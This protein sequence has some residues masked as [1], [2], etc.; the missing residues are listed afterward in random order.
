MTYKEIYTMISSAGYPCA[1]YQY[2]EGE[3]PALP[4]ILYYYPERNDFGA[5]NTNYA[6]ATDLNIEFYSAEKDFDAEAA[7]EQIL[8]SND[9]WYSKEEQYIDSE[10][11]Y[12]VL[13]T[14]T[15]PIREDDPEPAPEP[16]DPTEPADPEEPTEPTDPASTEATEEEETENGEG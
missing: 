7:I 10:H 2:Q 11:M 16:T 6:K 15:V 3:A 8:E 5:D 4:Y 14:M 13:Y 1:Y 9:I 12:E